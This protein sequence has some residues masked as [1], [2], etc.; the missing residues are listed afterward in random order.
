MISS[1]S[2]AIPKFIF[3]RYCP[4]ACGNFVIA[5]LLHHVAT[6]HWNPKLDSQR[7]HKDFDRDHLDW[8]QSKFQT[9]LDNHLKHEPHHPYQLDFVSA[10][11][12]RGD[13][14]NQ[15]QFLQ[16]MIKRQDRYFLSNVDQRKHIILR[17]NKSQIP[18]WAMGAKIVN[19]LVDPNSRRWLHRTRSIKL[20]G[21]ENNQFISKENH[22][23]FLASKYKQR[24]FD[25]PYS[26]DISAYRFLRHHV[27]EEPVMK[28]FQ[29]QQ[30]ILADQSNQAYPDQAWI[31]LSDL[32]QWPSY[33]T[34]MERVYRYLGFGQTNVAMLDA[35]WQHYYR[36]NIDP[37]LAHFQHD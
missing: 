6:A 28:I 3:V 23:E 13:D 26:F 7:T 35:C 36:T 19:V 18:Q 22:P 30:M 12:P 25:N 31:N 24:Q 8:F 32:F 10:K 4:G 34:S 15:E 14:L 37:V 27:M 16:E 21:R 2:H 5:C 29:S 20:F 9:D 11:H 17:L 1:S 33:S